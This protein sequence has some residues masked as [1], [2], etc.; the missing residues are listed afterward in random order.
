MGTINPTYLKQIQDHLI[1]TMKT[2]FEV[3]VGKM[4]MTTKL[5]IHFGELCILVPAQ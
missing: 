3:K 2:R 1:F 4:E 5:G